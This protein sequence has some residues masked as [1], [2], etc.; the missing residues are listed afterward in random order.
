MELH[1]PFYLYTYNRFPI[2]HTY[3]R[4]ESTTTIHIGG[5]LIKSHFWLEIL[6]KL[7]HQTIQIKALVC[8]SECPYD[9]ILG[10]TSMAQF[11]VWQDYASYK[12]YLQQILIPLMVRNNICVQPGKTRIISLTLQPNVNI[13]G[14]ALSVMVY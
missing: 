12:L 14:N 5:G 3:P 13:T 4:T 6:L 10:C 7:E 8:D 1:P 2:L 11:S 9:L